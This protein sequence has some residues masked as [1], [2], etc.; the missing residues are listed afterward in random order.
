MLNQSFQFFIMQSEI[1]RNKV[2]KEADSRLSKDEIFKKYKL[3]DSDFTKADLKK[4][5]EVFKTHDKRNGL[6]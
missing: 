5:M 4:V 6:L 2:I 1:N 3:K